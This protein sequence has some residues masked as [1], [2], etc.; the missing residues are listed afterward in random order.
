MDSKKLRPQKTI[1]LIHICSHTIY[2][3]NHQNNLFTTSLSLNVFAMCL[4]NLLLMFHLKGD[5]IS[6]IC[7]SQANSSFAQLEMFHQVMFQCFPIFLNVALII[8]QST[9][10]DTHIHT[11]RNLNRVRLQLLLCPKLF[12]AGREFRYI[13]MISIFIGMISVKQ[14]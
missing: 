5:V 8:I 3:G 14:H 2:T 1:V 9:L 11:K 12:S 7:F 4:S 6:C 10:F 13:C